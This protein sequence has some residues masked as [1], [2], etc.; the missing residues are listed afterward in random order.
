[1]L[2]YE[3]EQLLLLQKDSPGAGAT[4]EVVKGWE[5]LFTLLRPVRESR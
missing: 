4:G 3:Q 5:V 2:S 1:M